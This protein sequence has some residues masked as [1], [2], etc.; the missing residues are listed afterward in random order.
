MQRSPVGFIGCLWRRPAVPRLLK[1]TMLVKRHIAAHSSKKGSNRS[2][3][4]K[5]AAAE[6]AKVGISKAN[7]GI[8]STGPSTSPSTSVKTE[9]GIS[10][11]SGTAGSTNMGVDMSGPRHIRRE[12]NMWSDPQRLD[13]KWLRPRDPRRYKPDFGLTEPHSLRK[14][15]MRSPDER[16]RDAMGHDWEAAVRVATN[17]RRRAYLAYHKR[18]QEKAENLAEPGLGVK[19]AAKS[20]TD[21]RSDRKTK[22]DQPKDK[23]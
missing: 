9:S 13:T 23:K 1:H 18:D 11:R 5:I 15:F 3:N 4:I 21:A 19:L 10:S 22:R 12:D 8:T 2:G 6:P 14:Q 17:R 16:T 7:K 20:K